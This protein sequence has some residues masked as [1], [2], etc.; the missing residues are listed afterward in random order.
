MR[1][2]LLFLILFLYSG[3]NPGNGN[4]REEGLQEIVLADLHFSDLEGNVFTGEK[5]LGKPVFVHFWATW[6]RPC[7]KEMPEIEKVMGSVK[8]VTFIFPSDESLTLITSFKNK[9]DY[10]FEY[11]QLTSGFNTISVA[12]LPTT[13]IFD[14]NGK[15]TKKIVGSKSWNEKKM[16]ALF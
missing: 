16:K 13:Y 2:F 6:C 12:A 11:L 7:I 10:P 14:K 3:C 5:F 8:D 1:G 9:N 15:L 4:N